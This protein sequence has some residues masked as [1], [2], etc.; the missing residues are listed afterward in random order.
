[1]TEKMKFVMG[2]V[3]NVVGKGENAGNQHF[4]LCPQ[5]FPKPQTNKETDFELFEGLESHALYVY[6]FCHTSG[7]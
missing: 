1:M 7:H 2:R 3:K 6:M 5:C 4:L